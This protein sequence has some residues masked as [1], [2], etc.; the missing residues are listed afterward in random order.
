M[1][2]KLSFEIWAVNDA[3]LRK[4]FKGLQWSWWDLGGALP[5]CTTS[6]PGSTRKSNSMAWGLIDLRIISSIGCDFRE[7]RLL[8]SCT[9]SLFLIIL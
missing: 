5:W 7:E 1:G 9:R 4:N 3:G 6:A 8:A 2:R